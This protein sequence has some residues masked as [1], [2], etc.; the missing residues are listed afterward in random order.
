MVGC[1]GFPLKAKAGC[2]DWERCMRQAAP[3]LGCTPAHETG[4]ERGE[5]QCEMGDKTCRCDCGGVQNTG[6]PVL[7][8]LV[9]VWCAVGTGW[10][11]E[12]VQQVHQLLLEL[13][14]KEPGG[15]LTETGGR[16]AG[17]VPRIPA[18]QTGGRE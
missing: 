11:P 8:S 14:A 12:R 4:G 16:E 2:A 9:N 1:L 15:L 5:E 10:N 3:L 6:N 7:D 17:W 13:A 18:A